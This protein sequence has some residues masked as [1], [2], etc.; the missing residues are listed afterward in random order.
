MLPAISW[1]AI[2]T[3]IRLEPACCHGLQPERAEVL[4]TSTP[5]CQGYGMASEKLTPENELALDRIR[6]VRAEALK[7][8]QLAQNLARERR[9]L[10]RSLI[11]EGLSQA[12]IARQLGVSRQAIQKML[13]C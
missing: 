2:Q 7:H 9:D 6:E 5:G 11:G 3:R 8:V 1:S 4:T 13:A 12:D 10:I